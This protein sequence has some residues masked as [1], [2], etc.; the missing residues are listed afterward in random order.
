M[1]KFHYLKDKQKNIHG[2]IAIHHPNRGP[3]LG[4]CRL[5]NYQNL[6]QA[7]RE[8]SRLAR[9]M[10]YKS[11]IHQLPFTGGKTVLLE[12]PQ[13]LQ[14]RQT[15]FQTLGKSIQNLQGNYIA[16]M[17][18]GVTEQD[19]NEIAMHTNHVTNFSQAGGDP[20]PYTAK[21]VMLAISTLTNALLKKS[22]LKNLHIVIQG[23]GNVGYALIKELSKHDARITIA[24]KNPAAIQR[25]L[26]SFPVNVIEHEKIFELKSDI[27]VPCALGGTLNHNTIDKLQTKIIAGAANNQLTSPTLGYLLQKKNIFYAP[28]YV[29]NAGGLINCVSQYLNYSNDWIEQKI[30]NI[31]RLLI[32][33]LKLSSKHNLPTNIIADKITTNYISLFNNNI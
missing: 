31:E 1:F 9:S 29:I 25:C 21:G 22:E 33:I 26:E 16:A 24:D 8:V 28:D 5:A 17:D 23:I 18:S 13:T 12:S 27:F 7:L 19:M 32:N 6:W 20:S 10:S 11:A 15:I 3:A 4:G 14:N 2:I 30:Q